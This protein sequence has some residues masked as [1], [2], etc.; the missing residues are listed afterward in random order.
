MTT[1]ILV[2]F[3][4]FCDKPSEDWL[5]Q[6]FSETTQKV[7]NI[8]EGETVSHTFRFKNTTRHEIRIIGAQTS[9]TCT[10]TKV[11]TPV[12]AP[13]QTGE[14]QATFNP[15]T[16]AGPFHGSIL[17]FFDK[18]EESEI[19]LRVTGRVEPSNI[20]LEPSVLDLR[21][22]DSNTSM[23]GTI[24]IH[25]RSDAKWKINSVHCPNQMLKC[26]LSEVSRKSGTTY[27]LDV[28]AAGNWSRTHSDQILLYTSD[29]KNMIITLPV[30]MTASSGTF[31]IPGWVVFGTAEQR[32]DPQ[33]RQVTIKHSSGARAKSIVCGDP[34]ITWKIER[35]Q[36]TD[37]IK[38]R[39]TW[40]PREANKSLD[41]QLTVMLDSPDSRPLILKLTSRKPSESN[42]G[43]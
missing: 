41:T 43:K 25:H 23:T 37:D 31:L 30:R 19:Q 14:I 3:L 27:R 7:G 38:L 5:I 17:V 22:S 39:I 2:S 9:C 35:H 33:A 42:S 12:V 8:K 13:G 20:V 28:T 10:T 4:L 11:V 34:A 18:P 16:T 1:L 32:D 40:I 21:A 24:E 15:K 29:P 6:V 26:E 36:R